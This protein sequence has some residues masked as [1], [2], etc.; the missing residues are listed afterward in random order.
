MIENVRALLKKT[1]DQAH[2]QLW[3]VNSLN[4]RRLSLVIKLTPSEMFL[5]K[6]LKILLV[7]I[8]NTT[9]VWQQRIKLRLRKTLPFKLRFFIHVYIDIANIQNI[10]VDI[11]IVMCINLLENM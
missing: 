9:S 10:F 8:F 5:S 3:W 6:Y 4:L 11:F 1:M 7:P 2:E